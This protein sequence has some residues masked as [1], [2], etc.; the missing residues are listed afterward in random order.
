EAAE[1]KPD[2]AKAIAPSWLAR[3]VLREAEPLPPLKP[4]GALAAANG[5]E[6]PGDGPFL[7]EAAAA[8]RLAHLLLQLLPEVPGDRR[9]ETALTLAEAR[10][11]A[12][13]PARRQEVVGMALALLAEPALAELFAGSALA[14]APVSGAIRLPGGA[15]RTISGRID[16]LAVTADSVIIADFKTA[17]RPPAG[18]D[19]IPVATI[20]QLAAYAA[21]L[22]EIYPGRTMRALLVYTAN[23]ACFEIGPERLATALAALADGA[24]GGGTGSQ[25]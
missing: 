17:A 20:A 13:S 2:V 21:L 8:G 15:M 6:R 3:P 11:R 19:A 12:L 10:G 24:S 14:E 16:R 22:S 25:G 4:S 9:E 18:V 1:A 23:L 5:E 7:A